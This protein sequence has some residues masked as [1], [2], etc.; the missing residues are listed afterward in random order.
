MKCQPNIKYPFRS[1]VVGTLSLALAL[2]TLS[3]AAQD[4]NPPQSQ[5]QQQAQAPPAPQDQTQDQQQGPPQ[6]PS[7]Q[8][9]QAAPPQAPPPPDQQ[10]PPPQQYPS[11]TPPP[12][13]SQP[14]PN[15]QQNYPPVPPSLTLPAGT[16]ISIRSSDWL[17]SDHNKSGDIFTATL[18]QPLVV[19]GWVVARRGQNV[20]GKVVTAEKAGRITGVSKLGLELIELTLVDGQI[21][22][23][24]TQLLQGTGGT[25][26]GRDAAAVAGTTAFG[27]AVGAAADWGT[28]A[29]IGAGAGAAA[30]I[31][32]VLVT[33]GRPTIIGPEQLLTFRLHDPVTFS[34]VRGEMAYF[35][36]TQDDYARPARRQPYA[37][38]YP[39]PYGPPPPPYYY[40]YY[41]YGPYPYWGF[42]PGVVYGGRW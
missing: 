5:D 1:L 36:V 9:P 30:G 11:Q 25:S 31:I 20:T 21:L 15:D 38:R 29:A 34:T 23:V 4:Q 13:A 6:Y 27:A 10:A 18:A 37:R 32:G 24:K 40:P 12:Q 26:N 16:V 14:A 22:P 7:A 35:P 19:D 41:G 17:S 3:L 39:Y 8:E 33:R 28:G 42:P 2:T